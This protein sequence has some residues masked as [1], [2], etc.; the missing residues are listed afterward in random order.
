MKR[1]VR[2]W[3]MA[4]PVLLMALT[5]GSCRYEINPGIEGSGNITTETR[6]ADQDFTSIEVGNG[7][8][9]DISQGQQKSI[10]VETDD[11]LQ[12]L[13]QTRVEAGV[14][15]VEA[16]EDYDSSKPPKVSVRIPTIS[17]LSASA[18][19]SISSNGNIL[20]PKLIVESNSGSEVIIS[21]EAEEL[22][23]ETSSGSTIE[24]RG[25]AIRLETSSAS[26]SS[27]DASKLRANDIIAQTSSGSSTDVHPLVS[28]DAKAS[29]GSSIDY[30][31]KPKTLKKE[32]SSGGSVSQK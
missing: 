9:L 11:N 20:S 6:T 16:G 23:L 4:I 13:I 2:K 30:V 3:S 26:G 1:I 5:L 18:G 15:Y 19:S 17:G 27:I 22:A 7:I 12:R 25:K 14:L 8:E 28:L 31:N 32:E 29:S 24:V 21:V 10:T